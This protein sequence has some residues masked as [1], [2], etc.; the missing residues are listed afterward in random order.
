MRESDADIDSGGVQEA[1]GSED[2]D[3]VSTRRYTVAADEP[4]DVAIVYAVSAMKGVGPTELDRPLHEVVDADAL[5]R[6]FASAG[7][8][9]SA[10]L[11]VDDYKVTIADGGRELIVSK[12]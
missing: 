11:L 2:F 9:L 3:A 5:R 6:L 12:K 7:E 10:T 1:T 4:L 8:P